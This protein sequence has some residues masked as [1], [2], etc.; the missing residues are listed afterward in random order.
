MS[1]CTC[2]KCNAWKIAEAEATRLSEAETRLRGLLERA[3]MA[4]LMYTLSHGTPPGTQLLGELAEALG[5][6]ANG[7][8][9][10]L[11]E[12]LAERQA[13]EH[14]ESEGAH[15]SLEDFEDGITKTI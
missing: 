14:P 4:L 9:L 10:D 11:V 5:L 8:P 6:D 3:N 15:H 7:K 1:E 2:A 12:E 13:D